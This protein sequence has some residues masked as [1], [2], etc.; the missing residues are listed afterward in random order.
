MVWA[1]CGRQH[2]PLAQR[3]LLIEQLSQHCNLFFIL[4]GEEEIGPLCHGGLSRPRFA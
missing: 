2:R 3:V 1:R 4:Q